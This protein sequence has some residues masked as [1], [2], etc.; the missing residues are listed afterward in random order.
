MLQQSPNIK[1]YCSS[2]SLFFLEGKYRITAIKKQNL[3][4]FGGG[5][6][7]VKFISRGLT[8]KLCLL[9]SKNNYMLHVKKS[10]HLRNYVKVGIIKKIFFNLLV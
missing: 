1:H 6:F 9:L 3:L 5:C 8:C 2:L 4:Y 7:S 10:V